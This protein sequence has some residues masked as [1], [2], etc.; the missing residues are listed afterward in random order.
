[1]KNIKSRSN[2]KKIIVACAIVLA[3][4]VVIGSVAFISDLSKYYTGVVRNIS[5]RS[6]GADKLELKIT[7]FFPMGGCSVREVPLDEGQYTGDGMIDYDGS[8]GKYRI[9]VNFGDIALH[10]SFGKRLSDDGIWEI[11]TSTVSLKAKFARP[12]DHGFVLYIGSDT[13]ISVADLW[14]D[15]LNSPCGIIKIPIRVG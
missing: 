2:Y 6:K 10:R 3:V 7:Y 5:V 14:Y 11:K 13:P 4:A 12:S 15:E 8:L 9:M 1:M